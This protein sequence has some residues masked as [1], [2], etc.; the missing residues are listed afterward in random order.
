MVRQDGRA[1]VRKEDIVRGLLALGLGE[2]HL[3]QV[4]SSLSSFGYV[5]GGAEAVVDALIAAVGPTGTVMVPTFNHGQAEI[6]DVNSTPSVNGAI[7]EALRKR[8]Q[9]KRSVHPTHPYA[10]IG[11]MAEWLTG[12]HLELDTFDRNSPLGKLADKG[13]WVLLLGVGMNSN[14]AAHVGETLARVPCI[15]YRENPGKVV[16]PDGALR[17]AWSVLWR[18]GPC[19]L[20]WDPLEQAMRDTDM[21]ADGRIGDAQVMLMKAL[22]VVQTAFELTR[23][24]CPNCPTRPKRA[25]R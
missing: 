20:E 22:D 24:I 25:A 7:T 18:D 21:I 14:T 1:H 23:T 12:E 8:P 15:G 11:P 6:F 16:G 13:G 17:Q 19:L 2:G 4:H 9:A 5:E 10:A 3:V